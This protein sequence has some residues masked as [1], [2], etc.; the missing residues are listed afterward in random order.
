[1]A[2]GLT[3]RHWVTEILV[4]QLHLKAIARWGVFQ[5][6][7]CC[8]LV[9]A[10]TAADAVKQYTSW[11]TMPLDEPAYIQDGLQVLSSALSSFVTN[12]AYGTPL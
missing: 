6:S 2:Y 5:W 12:M 9:R 4:E 3:C 10:G 7:R 1:M 8:E 11:L